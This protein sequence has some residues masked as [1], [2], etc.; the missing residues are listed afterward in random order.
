MED[1]NLYLVK[2]AGHLWYIAAENYEV[3][4]GLWREADPTRPNREP[5]EMAVL[6]DAED[7]L[8]QEAP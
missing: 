3:A 7:V 8:I 4:L 6:A 1:R 2:D 5:D